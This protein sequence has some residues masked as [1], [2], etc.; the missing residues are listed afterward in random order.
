MNKAIA[1]LIVSALTLGGVPVRASEAAA[2]PRDTRR[3]QAIGLASY[4]EDRSIWETL[5]VGPQAIKYKVTVGKIPLRSEAGEA[6]GALT[7]V[8]YTI[9]ARLGEKRPVT[10][11]MNG[12]PG[13]SSAEINLRG[14][15]PK[16]VTTGADGLGRMTDNPDTW[17]PFSDLV[18]I[19]AMGTGFSRSFLDA[20]ASKAAFYTYDTDIRSLSDGM[21]SWLQDNGRLASPKYIVGESYSGYRAPRIAV[22]LHDRLN[23]PLQGLILLSPLMNQ[24]QSKQIDILPS[25]LPW[26]ATL[27]TAAAAELARQGK[28]TPAAMA[29]IEEYA[30]SDYAMAMLD[31]WRSPDRLDTVS[32]KVSLLTGVP[33]AYLAQ[34]GGR[35]E[36][37][38][39]LREIYKNRG[40]LANY[41]DV[42]VSYPR[43]FP[44]PNDYGMEFEEIVDNDHLDA[45]SN[46]ADYLTQTVGWRP[47][48]N[49]LGYG[50]EVSR[51]FVW[52]RGTSENESYSALRRI[53]V[54]NGHLQVAL[55][56]GYFD[57]ACP[58]FADTLAI[59]AIPKVAGR[60]RVRLL[61]Y[62]GG[63]M[64]YRTPESLHQFT[65]DVRSQVYQ[66]S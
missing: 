32:R 25:A 55:A 12:G 42:T 60:N 46:L 61:T 53:L 43:P 26:V 63:H 22:D 28:L 49:Y 8:A 66:A 54:E 19:D 48:M 33:L 14:L 5:R 2:Q 64:F 45:A 56:H 4:P 31:G 51:A 27:T 35:I 6:I 23:L 41:F 9:P 37:H 50:A 7:Y 15:G 16:R 18:F 40:L 62:P 3:G 21:F 17:L 38:S 52:A 10:F 11:A 1:L 34:T 13:A 20:A 47:D 36:P 39:Y 30:R 58:Y 29:P 24:D 57:I 65:Q 44:V 59:D